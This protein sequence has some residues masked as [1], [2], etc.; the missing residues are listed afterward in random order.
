MLNVP[1]ISLA[2][3]VKEKN[4]C[5]KILYN[6][7]YKSK[8]L[9]HFNYILKNWKIIKDISKNRIVKINTLKNFG[10]SKLSSINLIANL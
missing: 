8:S 6:S 5:Y 3:L 2:W 1:S 9:A 10:N 4:L 7:G